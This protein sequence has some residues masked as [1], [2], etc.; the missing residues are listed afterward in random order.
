MKLKELIKNL[1]A[2]KIKGDVDKEVTDVKTD[3]N[4]ITA[5]NLFI[6]LNGGSF[7]GHDY[8]KQ[9]ENYG[10]V[11]IVAERE[12]ESRLTQI[13]VKNTR[14]ALSIISAEF[15]GNSHKRLKLIGVVGTNGKTTTSHMIYEI[16]N[17][18]GINCGLI[19]TLGARYNDVCVQ[20]TLTTPDPIELHK[21][22]RDMENGKI[23]TVV[24]EVSAHAIHFDKIYGL[25]FEVGIFTNLTRDHLDFFSDMDT[26]KKAKLKFFSENVKGYIV[27]NID[28]KCG[29][30]ISQN[31]KSVI[32]YGID[33]PSDNFAMDINFNEGKT[34][35]I[36][37]LFDYVCNV[38]ISFIGK[39]NVSNALAALSTACLIGVKPQKAVKSIEKISGVSGRL[40]QVYQGEFS[41]FVDYAHT[42]DG[43]ENVLKTLKKEKRGKLVLLFGCGGN[44]DEGKREK[45]GEIAGRYADFTVIT[46]DNPRFEEPMDIISS[47]E[48]GILKVNR[49][50]VIIESREDAISYALNLLKENDVLLIAGK[51][52]ENYQEILGIKIPYNDKDT[53]IELMRRRTRL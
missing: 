48:K 12:I 34:S 22:F 45:M 28:D 36:A 19:G 39:F 26:Y 41:I 43:L 17:K 31:Y 21:L 5:G 33:N 18:S 37:N 30:E 11:A 16:L 25:E 14:R 51:G 8:V 13:I 24:M 50:Y 7:D 10:A 23:E 3:S 2:I 52:S 20:P 32:T 40:E 38:N 6:C 1:D 15:F 49:N 44:R 4:F 27:A 42:P 53:V 47:I 9:A 29:I 35:F 46:S